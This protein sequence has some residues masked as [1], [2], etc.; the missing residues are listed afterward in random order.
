MGQTLINEN[1]AL[2]LSP[3]KVIANPNKANNAIRV[4]KFTYIKIMN[5]YRKAA[6]LQ[7]K[8]HKPKSFVTKYYFLVYIFTFY[9]TLSFTQNQKTLDSL[10]HVYNT[11]DTDTHKVLML[12]KI[13]YLYSDNNN[14]TKAFEY[15]K[16]ALTLALKTKND[17]HIYRSYLGL[18]IFSNNIGKV[19][20]AL[21]YYMQTLNYFDPSN[22]T[23]DACLMYTRI[24]ELYTNLE[25]YN[26]AYEYYDKAIELIS[27]TKDSLL[28]LQIMLPK[29]TT[30]V[31]DKK[32][33][34]ARKLLTYMD[35][36]GSKNYKEWGKY[37][38]LYILQNLWLININEK[39][40]NDALNVAKQ[41][42]K[43]AEQTKNK[44]F[45]ISSKSLLAK[46]FF[47]LKDLTN[48]KIFT[49]EVI[50]ECLILD[51]YNQ[52]MEHYVILANI[53][54]EIE[55]Y[56]DA[57]QSLTNALKIAREGNVIRSKIE[58]L[59]KLS[60]FGSFI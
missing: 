23:S 54:I 19:A 31:S 56:K 10:I 37:Q 3:E 12:R 22:N 20:D 16:K 7:L 60:N 26:K 29:L 13:A 18:G 9:S 34:E 39:K 41:S 8:K 32:Y 50:K 52:L 14:S 30:Y 27:P 38:K 47:E 44:E 4:D 24:A 48:A 55:K 2:S 53:D 11:C 15:G 17:Y 59:K 28:K 36:M 25:N 51:D 57:K 40:L 46:T 6:N 42:L 33:N 21:N 35:S 45:V 43:L 1:T 49:L 58:I 5:Y